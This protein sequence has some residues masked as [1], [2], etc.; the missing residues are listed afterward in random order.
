MVF[1]K[2]KYPTDRK[3]FAWEIELENIIKNSEYNCAIVS[4]F[5]VL[6]S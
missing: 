1:W 3:L 5:T 4:Q 6:F 2:T